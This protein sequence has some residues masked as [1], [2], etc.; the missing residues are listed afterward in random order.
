MTTTDTMDVSSTVAQSLRL[1]EAGCEIIRITAPSISSAKNLELIKKSLEEA[2]CY[3][4]LVADIHFTPNA[5]EVAARIVQKCGLI[6]VTMRIKRSLT[7]LNIQISN[8]KRS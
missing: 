1:V 2:N 5:A 6:L 3:V 8:T 7:L 4:P